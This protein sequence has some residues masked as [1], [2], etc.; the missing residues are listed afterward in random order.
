MLN[1]ALT[2]NIAAGKST[3]ADFFRAWGAVVIDSDELVRLAQAPGSPVLAAIAARFG[4]D[5]ILADGALDR[6]RLRGRVMGNP[7]ALA[8]LNAI[9]HPEVFRRRAALI[10]EAAARGERIVVSDIPLLFEVA[11]PA[12]FDAV[13]LVDAPVALRRERLVATRGLSAEEADRM[14]ASQLPADSKRAGSDYIIENAG[15][16]AD[17]KQ[18]A[19]TVWD[20]LVRRA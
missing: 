18:A 20:S 11:D 4:A 15:N 2:G 12:A 7:D 10:Q 14:I 3:V 6:A 19:R 17:L 13:V 9:V 1:V 8:A 16:L 5:V